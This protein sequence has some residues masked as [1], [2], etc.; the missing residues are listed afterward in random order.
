MQIIDKV[1]VIMSTQ[2]YSYTYHITVDEIQ[3]ETRYNPA[4]PFIDL[5]CHCDNFDNKAPV[6]QTA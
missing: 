3:R 6:T 2:L 4:P 5:D 1:H